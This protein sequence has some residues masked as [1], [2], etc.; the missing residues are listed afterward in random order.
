MAVNTQSIHSLMPH[1]IHHRDDVSGG[2][3]GIR[4]KAVP[5]TVENDGLRNPRQALGFQPLFRNLT[6]RDV[7]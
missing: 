2:L 5:G 4:G 1:R 3:Q 6:I 7:A